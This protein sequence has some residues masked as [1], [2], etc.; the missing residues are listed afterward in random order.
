MVEYLDMS[1]GRLIDYLRESGQLE[2]TIVMFS[3]DHGASSGDAGLMESV[4]PRGVPNRDNSLENFGRP[5][6]FVGAGPGF[7][8]AGSAPFR[9]HKGTR[10]EGGLRAAAFI[11]YP[12]AIP[13]GEVNGTFMTIMDVLPT[14]LD[15]AGTEH[16]GASIYKG[17][18]IKGIAGRSF[19]PHLT[20][21]SSTV[22]LPGD[23]AEWETNWNRPPE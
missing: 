2:N 9:G 21:Q 18:E 4:Y 22:H 13:A 23:T 6:S 20:G 11:H 17:R 8:E 16:P 5:G 1:V 15:I 3:S 14:F 12:A 10:R 7:A 19:W